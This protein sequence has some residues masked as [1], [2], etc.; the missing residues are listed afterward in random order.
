MT[1]PDDAP[2][3]QQQQPLL[4]RR[5]S[6]RALLEASPSQLPVNVTARTLLAQPAEALL[7]H[8]VLAPTTLRHSQSQPASHAKPAT[9]PAA[10]A[11]QQ[12]PAGV[13]TGPISAAASF[14]RPAPQPADAA[15]A[16]TAPVSAAPSFRRLPPPTSAPAPQSTGLWDAS[17]RQQPPPSAAMSSRQMHAAAALDA[18]AAASPRS[19]G[20]SVAL[21]ATQAVAGGVATPARSPR[22][23]P[24]AGPEWVQQDGG[25]SA[26]LQANTLQGE[27]RRWR[28][29]Q[30]QQAAASGPG[31]QARA[32]WLDSAFA[33]LGCKPLG[34]V[35][36]G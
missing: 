31:V 15:D 26:S 9:A 32:C 22:Q 30:E 29:Q 36:L 35:A 11:R 4:S 25:T 16:T 21:T 10:A 27:S 3:Q 7:A 33:V 24:A 1:A 12:V 18:Q 17:A 6:A 14:R 13:V 2:T 5:P 19:N 28:Q 8:A 34:W 20:V 23:A